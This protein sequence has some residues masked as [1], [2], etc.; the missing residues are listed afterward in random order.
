MNLEY[1]A[2]DFSSVLEQFANYAY[3]PHTVERIRNASPLPNVLEMRQD[4]ARAG[5]AYAFLKKGKEVSL[6]GFSDLLALIEAAKKGITLRPQELLEV[7]FFLAACQSVSKAFSAEEEPLLYEIAQTIDPLKPLANKIDGAIDLSGQVRMDATSKLRSL[8][9]GLIQAKAD[10]SAAAKR[11]IK[12]NSNSLVDTVSVSVGSRLCVLM[13]ATDKYK[14]GGMIHGLSQSGAASYVEPNVLVPLNNKVAEIQ[15]EIEEE[16]KRICQELSSLVRKNARALESN[17]ES[18]ETIDLA[19]AKGRWMQSHDGTIPLLHTGNHAIRLEHAIHPLLDLQK[20]VANDYNIPADK[21]CLMITGSNM[22]G[23]TVTLKTIGLFLLLA[24][25]GFPVSAH[26]A[27]LPLYS[28]FFF[29]IGDEQ[30]IEQNLSTFSAHAQKLGRI[31]NLANKDTFV[32]LDEIGNG[33]DPL[34]GASLAQAVLEDLMKKGATVLTSTHYNQVKSFGKTDPKVL[35]GSVEFDLET[36]KPTYRFLEGVSGASCA[37]HIARQ[38][39]LSQDI[40]ARASQIKEDSESEN[41]RQ[42]EALEHQQAEV[43]KQK[44]R[45]DQLI[46]NAHELQR[47]AQQDQTKW[48]EQKQRLDTQY[49]RELEDMLYEKKEEAKQIIRDLKKSTHKASHE[50]I[51]QMAKLDELYEEQ[52]GQTITPPEQTLKVGDYVRIAALNNH[53]EIQA[54]RKDKAIVLVNGRRVTV[55]LDQLTPM[56]K[57]Q[58][59]KSIRRATRPERSFKAFPMELNI[60]GMHVEEGIEALDHYLDQAVYHRVKNVRIIHGMGTGAL[61]NAVWE[62]L[63]KHPQVKGITS[64]GPNDGGLGATLVELK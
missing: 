13:K 23:K 53:G 62:D 35:V 60:I 32:L 31:T 46:A 55:E 40:M 21:A 22:G 29:D 9:S 2:V 10:L 18:V 44:D 20:A 15:L 51:D 7:S 39:G 52:E 50:Q 48:A 34:E 57:P 11:F 24:H 17:E 61:R 1:E 3:S 27:L 37:F 47:K 26:S 14:Y 4:L 6:G 30:S 36:L 45:F 19:I 28:Q 56:A 38:F 41:A 5:E 8:D 63:R 58:A 42:L 54:L 49:T 16:K 25:S 59:P 12:A 43:Q 33:T 64:G